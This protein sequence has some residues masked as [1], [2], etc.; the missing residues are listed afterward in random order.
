MTEKEAKRRAGIIVNNGTEQKFTKTIRKYDALLWAS[1]I[2]IL[3]G[4]AITA[5]SLILSKPAFAVG[6]AIGICVGW[7]CFI[8]APLLF[9]A[10]AIEGLRL[11]ACMIVRSREG[12]VHYDFDRLDRIH[13]ECALRVLGK[14]SAVSVLSIE[15]N[16]L[17]IDDDRLRQMKREA[18][19]LGVVL[20]CPGLPRKYLAKIKVCEAQKGKCNL[21]SF[22]VENWTGPIK[23][24]A[25]PDAIRAVMEADVSCQN[26]AEH[27]LNVYLPLILEANEEAIKSSDDSL[28]KE[29]LEVANSVAGILQGIADGN[30]QDRVFN[31]RATLSAV[32]NSMKMNGYL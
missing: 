22:D 11:L 31:A 4:V 20:M 10:F 13:I 27:I 16:F 19:D 9:Y 14:N 8:G 2:Q 12:D 32:T 17:A 18:K 29:V 15:D 24:S 3:I 1:K 28:G 6:S 7:Y 23:Y 21:A 26:E 25:L 30:K 5:S